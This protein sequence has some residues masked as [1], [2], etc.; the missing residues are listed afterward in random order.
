M[1][2]GSLF[3]VSQEAMEVWEHVQYPTQ[4]PEPNKP[5]LLFTPVS[6]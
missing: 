2:D 4:D 6:K 5:I 1:N 3:H